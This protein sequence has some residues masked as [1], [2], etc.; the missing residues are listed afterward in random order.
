MKARYVP[1]LALLFGLASIASAE[2]VVLVDGGNRMTGTITELS[3]GE[4]QFSI[5]GA[6]GVDIDWSNVLELRSPDRFYIELASGERFTG[7]LEANAGRVTITENG[8]TRRVAMSEVLRI[9]PSSK[10]RFVE[11]LGGSVDAGFDFLSANDEIDWTLNATLEHRT[12]RHLTEASISS[13]LRRRD[14]STAQRRNHFDIASRRLLEN[15]WFVLSKAIIEEDRE[16][17]LDSRALLGLALGRTLS[18]SHRAIFSMYGGVD[19]DRE[20]FRG[21]D[22]DTLFEV[23]A[24]I[25]WDWFD[26]GGDNELQFEATTYYAPD[27]SRVRVEVQSSL[28]R[29][30]VNDF[31]WALYLYES[32]NSDPPQQYEKSDLGIGITIG[33]SF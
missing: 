26:V 33:R 4:L 29:E 25:E 11:R 21:L 17:D 7:T 23:H 9:E 32:Y 1:T 15:R 13:L 2:D 31:Y 20:K 18:Q 8:M 30:I 24:A 5:A 16:L 28:R 14:S 22:S 12:K 19:A 10:S 6:G 27:D 3:R